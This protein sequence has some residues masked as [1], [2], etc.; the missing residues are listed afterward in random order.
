MSLDCSRDSASI[1]ADLRHRIAEHS[2]QFENGLLVL[3]AGCN[4]PRAAWT[5][6]HTLTL[7]A[8][9][10]MGPTDAKEQPGTALIADLEQ[11]M[12]EVAAT[13]FGAAW[14]DVRLPSCTIANL[15]VYHAFGARGKIL[16]PA[17]ADGGHFS[18]TDGG[19]PSIVGMAATDLPFDAVEQSLDGDAA[20][21]LIELTQ[22]TL[23][24]LGRSVILHPDT[25][26][27]VVS[28]AR[29]VGARTIYDA[30]HVA[31]LIAG[32]VFPNP[33]DSGVDLMTMSTYK[34]LGGP[35]GAIIAGRNPD[36]AAKI[37]HAIDSAFLA[38]QGA[39]RYPNLLA[40]LLLHRDGSSEPRQ[41]VAN[42]ATLKSALWR[43]GVDVL[44]PDRAAETH[45]V[46][47]PIGTLKEAIGKMRVLEAAG[48]LVGRCPVP[49]HAKCHGL[50]FGTQ[51][52]TRRGVA[53]DGIRDVAKLI[54][55]LL[56][57]QQVSSPMLKAAK[58]QITEL[59][60]D[61]TI[62][63]DNII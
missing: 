52:T 19:T 40:A 47:V 54:A 13:V 25:L 58:T 2:E 22:P 29:R 12:S 1:L 24:M 63:R 11:A 21:R 10:A 51:Y 49:G 35:P 59:L 5:T 43:H 17:A 37:Q 4:V 57:V 38:N 15:A 55:T 34:T 60:S 14:A 31:G 20:A 9:P 56:Q 32:G 41:V 3:Y 7:D 27:I 16:T 53:V 33:L 44:A 61:A 46:V 18:Q 62:N 26:D 36:D 30:S 8:M 23:V 6:P 42:A 39:A 28:S 45:Q 48:I 50:R